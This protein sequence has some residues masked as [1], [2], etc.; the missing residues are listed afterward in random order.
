MN[1]D[2]INTSTLF[3][4]ALRSVVPL[5]AVLL[6]SLFFRKASPARLHLI[7]FLGLCGCLLLPLTSLVL[8]RWNLGVLP[9]KLTSEPLGTHSV[10]GFFDT[11]LHTAL[12][13]QPADDQAR[14]SD[15]VNLTSD[16]ADTSASVASAEFVA[17]MS[18]SRQGIQAK[19]SP[20]FQWATV[21]TTPTL[22]A[23]AWSLG[24]LILGLRYVLL[25]LAVDRFLCECDS[26]EDR[27]WQELLRGCRSQMQVRD[28]IRLVFHHR[29]MPPMVFGW[30]RPVILLPKSAQLWL[31]EKSKLVL[32][33]ELAH[34]RRR[35][36]A[37]QMLAGL[38][39]SLC[40][41]NPLAWWASHEMRRLREIA[42]DDLVVART[43]QASQYADTLLSVAKSCRGPL[44]AG[45]IAI[46]RGSHV[47]HRI[48]CILDTARR[49]SP[50]SRRSVLL[51]ACLTFGLSA[52]VGALGLTTRAQEAKPA[53]PDARD[54]KK[55]VEA[56][57]KSIT[58]RV[59]DEE[60]Q[61][62]SDADI[63]VSIWE[64]DDKRDYP[65][66]DFKTNER[67]SAEV[68]IPSRLRIM[69]IWPSKSGYVPQFLNFAD[70][71]HG[72]GKDIPD[73]FTF[74]LKRGHRI[75]GKVVD[76][77]GNPIAGAKVDVSV[78]V[79]EPVWDSSPSP[80][81]SKWLANGEDAA[82]TNDQG[83]WEVTNTPGPLANKEYT[84]GLVVSHPDYLGDSRRD[85][86][87]DTQG[88]TTEQLRS[89]TASL[90]LKKGIVLT[91]LIR[92]SKG[93]LVTKG[94]VIWHERPYL[95]SG[96]NET[97]I[98]STGRYKTIHLAP[99]KRKITVVAS[100]FAPQQ[101]EVEISH[102]LQD[103]DFKL[104]N[105]HALKI[106]I[107]DAAG[108]PL[109]KAYAQIEEWRSTEAL[110][111]HVH[112]N[113]LTSGIPDRAD[114]NGLFTWD[115]APADAVK[116][117]VQAK[118]YG[119]Q[120]IA[121]IAKEEP[122]E[123]RLAMPPTIFG[124]VVDSVTKKLIESFRVIPVKAFRPD[125][126]STDFQ[127]SSGAKGE[128][129]EYRLEFDSYGRTGERYR[130]R[131]EADGYRI[132]LG[133]KDLAV[134][135]D[136]VQEDF[137]LEPKP[138][139]VGVVKDSDGKPVTEFKVA[140]G[141]PTIAPQFSTDRLD[142][143]FGIAFG[144][145]GKN[146]FELAATFEPSLIRVFNDKGFAELLRQPDEPIGTIRLQPWASVS[147]R[148]MQG[149][150]PIAN[151]VMYFRPVVSRELTE[152]R[153]QDSYFVK[154]NVDG[155]FRFDKL[156]PENG[157]V[158]AYLGPWR[159][160]KLTSSESIPLQMESGKIREVVLGGGGATVHGRVVATGRKNE[161]LNKNWSLNHLVKR[162]AGIPR[163]LNIAP[164][165]FDP[166]QPLS[167]DWTSRPD[168]HSWLSSQQHHFAR[169]SEDGRLKIRGV[170]AGEYDLL[171]QL[172]EQPAGCLVETIGQNVIPLTITDAQAAKGDFELGDIE[173]PCR[174]GP[175]I[176]SDMR[177]F[178]FTDSKGVGK[179]VNDMQGQFVLFHVW[180]TWC[181]PCMASMPNLKADVEGYSKR[182]LTV[183][184]LNIDDSPR[185]AEEVA[186]K[187]ELSWS[188]NYLGAK[189][190]LMRQLA[191]SSVPVYYL[192]G[193]DGM[194]VGSSNG[195]EEMKAILGNHLAK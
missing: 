40:W 88:V 73:S 43:S 75:S 191:V 118:G 85:E 115:W 157:S 155:Y 140:V 49:R 144:V 16:T 182:P 107:T 51:L 125:F 141:T 110:Y 96:V 106:R 1:M 142:N 170:E 186:R 126:Y 22:L 136:P 70:G 99:G 19:F 7:W 179:L 60:D 57:T 127:A 172:Y 18:L 46:S 105:G 148:L 166:R 92:D 138:A 103:V 91:G 13:Q 30:L 192:I 152:A 37:T 111:S 168:F 80:M 47:G 134:G 147:G 52:L 104:E 8:P 190:D 21:P 117:S 20:G 69:R 26:N 194:L 54:D 79:S 38:A 95:A 97:E 124:S 193:P 113:V 109:P 83:V 76:E 27:G 17:P 93:N 188:Q 74:H 132:A 189:S 32:L 24:S 68:P 89:G 158:N 139:W 133:Q 39:C 23:I 86:L 114:E 112:P 143:S 55:E 48:G 10:F 135:D 64:Y 15:P 178:K 31:S 65:K 167:A 12:G 187:H 169:L 177:A 90:T 58:L 45:G 175:R 181:G 128:H 41:F 195:W 28:E 154:T 77:S 184:G 121:L 183:V 159:E 150:T 164:L 173:I 50:F 53:A 137:Q 101:R 82:V 161:E 25:N 165:S 35:D 160:S 100:G 72:E 145:K 5:V 180:A 63:H 9:A 61:P 59:L 67:G 102:G 122:H 81:I 33:H 44:V 94:I 146:R 34:V 163:P 71:K 14:P 149:E 176:G 151:E 29:E 156:P 120:E 4:L 98:D 42:C 123:V 162:N 153:F 56:T 116:F 129:G 2:L 130:G 6:I 108:N 87:K 62:L 185:Q 3:G 66:R 36:L 78:E 174:I 119:T 84:F 11:R 171:I 131:I